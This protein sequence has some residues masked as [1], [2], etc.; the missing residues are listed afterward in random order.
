MIIRIISMKFNIFIM[1]EPHRNSRS[2]LCRKLRNKHIKKRVNI[3]GLNAGVNRY[4]QEIVDANYTRCSVERIG[5][6][7]KAMFREAER[8]NK[9]EYETDTAKS[10]NQVLNGNTILISFNPR[11]RVG[12]DGILNVRL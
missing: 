2:H 5:A 3:S 8:G 4:R 1:S 12:S 9:P 7:H 11:S 10:S 6:H